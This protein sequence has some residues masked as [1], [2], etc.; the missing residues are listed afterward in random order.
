MS[1]HPLD[2]TIPILDP[3]HSLAPS[4]SVS[5]P[6]DE[7]DIPFALSFTPESG[8]L[9]LNTDESDLSPLSSSDEEA[10]NI[11]AT[12]HPVMGKR[13][14]RPRDAKLSIPTAKR[15]PSGPDA[16]NPPRSPSP[17]DQPPRITKKRK[18]N[19]SSRDKTPAATQGPKSKPG[20]FVSKERCHQCRSLPRHAYMRCTSDDDSATRPC[21]K[22]FCASCVL[23]RSAPSHNPLHH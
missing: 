2:P 14:L 23:K 6:N 20:S 7:I 1:G 5:D 8:L 4:S 21:R 12:Q 19:E 13:T 17:V 15:T 9:S 16:M 22:L 11:L 3:F 10:E 18:R